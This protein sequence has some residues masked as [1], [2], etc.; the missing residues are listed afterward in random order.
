M[1]RGRGLDD[2]VPQVEHE[3]PSAQGAQDAVR[4]GVERGAARDQELGIEVAL[5][6]AAQA[7]LYLLRG[8]LEGNRRVQADAVRARR[9][10]EPVVGEPGAPGEGDDGDA[11]VPRL[12]RRD[13]GGGR[14]DAPALEEGVR[15]YPG[16]ALEQLDRFRARLDLAFKELGDGGREQVTSLKAELGIIA[17]SLARVT[18]V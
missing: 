1:L 18:D 16:P 9:L 6:A 13:D 10:G 14:P 7:A 11:R 17:T 2:A 12:Q 15:E 3:R 5:H 4:L 8:P